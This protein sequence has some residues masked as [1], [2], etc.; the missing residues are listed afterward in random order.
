MELLLA[1]PKDD[2]AV[3]GGL[4]PIDEPLGVGVEEDDLPAVGDGLVADLN[5]ERGTVVVSS[6]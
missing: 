3:V 6:R 4:G 5:P 2:D 1:A